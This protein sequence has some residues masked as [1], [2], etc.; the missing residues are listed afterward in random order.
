[1][2]VDNGDDAVVGHAAGANDAQRADHLAIDPVGGGDD[3]VV[4][5]RN[6]PGIAADVDM[7][8]LSP[9]GNTEQVQ[10]V[11]LLLEQLEQAAQ[12]VHVGR[13]F[14]DVQQ[15]A[16][17]GDDHGLIVRIG[18]V[19]A[20]VHRLLHQPGN[21]RAQRV[22]LVGQ[23]LTD[24]MEG[25]ARELPVEEIGGLQQLDLGVFARNEQDAVLHVAVGR[26]DDEQH[27]P[28]GQADEFDVAEY[29]GALGRE[30]HARELR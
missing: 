9:D 17:A 15:L 6:Q 30:H 26:D 20:G 18:G 3:R 29:L 28:V 21:I 16:F 24:R 4:V 7:Y 13:H 23:R 11:G 19:Q 25:F 27:A 2:N 14:R 5:H 10:Q 22:K 12:P 1:R 8:A